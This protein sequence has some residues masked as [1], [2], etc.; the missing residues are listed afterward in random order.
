MG[1]CVTKFA[2]RFFKYGVAFRLMFVAAGL[3]TAALALL[4]P[5]SLT[6]RATDATSNITI[7]LAW[8]M[9]GLAALAAVDWLVHDLGGHL[10]FKWVPQRLR[11][12][13]CLIPYAA[14][15]QCYGI[16]AFAALDPAV[17]TSWI[18][19]FYYCVCYVAGNIAAVAMARNLRE[20]G[21]AT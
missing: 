17:T 15:A 16:F 2:A 6:A 18:L 7:P 1:E 4:S 14:L 3:T 8:V 20:T 19:I 11:H 21:G 13:V 9:G 5:S 12:Q 10:L